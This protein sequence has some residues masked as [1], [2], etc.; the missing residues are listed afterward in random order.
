L[1]SFADSRTVATRSDGYVFNGKEADMAMAPKPVLRTVSLRVVA[2]PASMPRRPKNADVRVR[3]HLT[4]SEVEALAAAAKKR[5]RYGARDAFA[6][7]FAA[8]HGFRVSELCALRWDQIDLNAGLMHVN[9]LKNGEPST[10]TLRGDEIRA[11]RQLRRDWPEG[12]FVFVT[13]RGAPFSR[14]GFAKMVERAG[15]AAGLAFPVH[16]HMLR[17]ACGY[18]F[19]NDG[20]DTRSLQLWLGH[21]AIQHTVKYTQLSAERFKDW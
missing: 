11:L 5:G 14:G 2:E 3:E 10:H 21:K 1:V 16:F 17:H 8:R 4:P 9:R 18:K 15:E 6:I 19:A 20:Q 7:R 13:E 12:R